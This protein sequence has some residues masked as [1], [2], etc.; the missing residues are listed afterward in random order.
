MSDGNNKLIYTRGTKLYRYD[1]DNLI[2]GRIMKYENDDKYKIKYING[3]PF[4][5]AISWI[6]YEEAHNKFVRLIPD[7]AISFNIVKDKSIRDVM[8]LVHPLI[9]GKID[10]MPSAVCRQ[11]VVDIFRMSTKATP[12]EGQVWAGISINKNNCPAECNIV[13]FMDCEEF[14][15]SVMVYAYIDDTLDDILQFVFENKFDNIL[16]D[17]EKK[18]H[19]DN[20]V[21]ICT[22]LRELLE[23][24]GFMYDFHEVLG[25]I[26]VPFVINKN[27]EHLLANIIS[28]IEQKTVTN[29]YV[30]DYSKEIDTTEFQRPYKLMT[31]DCYIKDNPEAKKIHIVGYDV[32]ENIPYLATKYGTEDKEEIIKQMGFNVI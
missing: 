26:E 4:D 24:K 1:N 2:L 7:A 5:G 14:Q 18:H 28:Q 22:S 27:N 6:T 25:V 15:F 32:D 30:M 19:G 9:D 13:Q 17:Y 8:V 20:L 23:D 16:E 10:N 21:G 12:V 29:I 11:D 31:S 3:A